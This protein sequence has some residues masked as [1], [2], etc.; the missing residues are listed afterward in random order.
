LLDRA[1]AYSFLAPC[2]AFA[3]VAMPAILLRTAIAGSEAVVRGL[4]RAGRLQHVALGARATTH[5]PDHARCL[6][7]ASTH[8]AGGVGF[9]GELN[10]VPTR[11][12]IK[13][14]LTML[15]RM[16]HRGA[17]GCEANTGK[18]CCCCLACHITSGM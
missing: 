10:K 6:P 13:D 1:A 3:L 9:V 5:A 7:A 16:E 15:C 8:N 2:L 12:C 11:K 18:C 4:G 17:C 14:S